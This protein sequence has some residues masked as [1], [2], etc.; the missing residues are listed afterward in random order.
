[1]RALVHV[2]FGRPLISYPWLMSTSE[3]R[4][5]PPQQRRSHESLARIMQAGFEL[6]R[7]Q[8]FDG[9]TLQ[10]VSAR[11]GVSVGSIYA[12]VASREDLIMAIYEQ[13]MAWTNENAL[14]PAENLLDLSPRDRI[15]TI[16]TASATSTLAHGDVLRVFMSEAPMHSAI[17][18][19]GAQKSHAAAAEF[20]SAIL[21][22]REDIHHPQ[23]ELAVDIAWRILY[24]TMA[25]RITHGARFESPRSVGDKI[26]VR[27]TARAIADYLL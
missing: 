12:R 11:A 6:L 25:R 22:R 7:E 21:E 2:L 4:I 27:E 24:C 16:V 17:W 5:R 13:Q 19:R 18:D 10:E 1:M 8:G 14:P 3:K 26:L 23:P 9:F 20:M 15:E